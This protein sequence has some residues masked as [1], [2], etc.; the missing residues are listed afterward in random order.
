[1][2]GSGRDVRIQRGYRETG[3]DAVVDALARTGAALLV[4]PAGSGRTTLIE[5]V[6]AREERR[7]RVWWC[8]GRTVGAPSAEAVLLHAAGDGELLAAAGG[9]P[10]TV[11]VD[12]A[13]LLDDTT[14]RRL[15]LLAERRDELGLTLA[16]T[17]RL[18]RVGPA[19]AGLDA[20]LVRGGGALHLDPLPETAIAAWIAAA[21]AEADAS[22]VCAATGGWPELVAAW[23]VGR[24]AEDTHDG[25]VLHDVVAPRLAMLPDTDRRIV[26]ALAFGVSPDSSAVWHAAGADHA[27]VDAALVTGLTHGLLHG[28]TTLVPAVADAVRRAAPREDRRR[29][30]EAVGSHGDRASLVQVADHLAALDDASEAAGAVYARAADA[31]RRSAPDHAADL[32]RRA[33]AAGR[34]A[35]DL[36]TRHAAALVAAGHAEAA[37]Q[38]VAAVRRDHPGLDADEHA[39]LARLSGAAWAHLGRPDLAA[40]CYLD[41]GA[42]QLLAAV[43][44]LVAGDAARAAEVLG[45]RSATAAA[46]AVVLL[47]EG[48]RAWL[49]GRA[50]DAAD[51]LGRSARLAELAGGVEEWPDS[52]HALAALVAAQALDPELAERTVRAALEREVGSGAY[53]AR[54]RAV[55]AWVALRAGRL[56]EAREAC[57]AAVALAENPRDQ[58]LTA[59]LGAAI[60]LR[61]RDPIELEEVHRAAA[62]AWGRAELDPFEAEP[63]GEIA[64]L[65]ARVGA[66]PEVVLR[67]FERIAASL[68]RPVTLAVPLAWARV[69]VAVARDDASAA[70]CAADELTALETEA[71]DTDGDAVRLLARAAR[72]FADVLA[73]KVAADEVRTVAALLTER[74]LVFEAARLVGAAGLRCEDAAAARAL[75]G[76][77]RRLRATQ[78]RH[79]PSRPRAV[80]SLSEREREVA[81]RVL[82]GRTHREIG[83]QLYI[84]A[85]TVEHHVARVRQKLGATTRA[86]LLAAIREELDREPAAT[87]T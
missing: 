10:T 19:L 57:A 86:E 59:A 7:R 8:R 87:A 80:A 44:L 3:S 77:L 54:H 48:A 31:T 63:A 26:T 65:A 25:D 43:P 9:E 71:A 52:P 68:G 81:R 41:A 47:A 72:T 42:G 64:H 74:G 46:D 85:K 55:Q 32:Y 21:A 1:V 62:D 67:P 17:R 45:D 12:D 56:D 6:A 53:A 49:S 28:E 33:V 38:L 11:L 73:G 30:A 5:D 69:V 13:H 84:S 4:G 78:V 66:D 16:A 15:T 79:T 18:V 70:R 23:L 51:A 35:R 58:V 34:P 60:A 24:T 83:A 37:V 50:V 75:L 2:E 27:A 76:D 40:S 22:D 29:I 14:L 20:V 36:A 61:S 39:E 82:E